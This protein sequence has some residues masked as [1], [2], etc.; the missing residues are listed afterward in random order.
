ME[1]RW[2]FQCPAPALEAMLAG[3]MPLSHVSRRASGSPATG[4]HLLHELEA[5]QILDQAI[6][7]KAQG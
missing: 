7:V 4:S 1:A 5:D 6:G 3:R 2:T